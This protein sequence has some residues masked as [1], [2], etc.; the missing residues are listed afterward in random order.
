[1]EKRD[2]LDNMIDIETEDSLADS[3]TSN[4]FKNE[5]ILRIDGSSTEFQ[6]FFRHCLVANEPCIVSNVGADWPCYHLWVNQ[7]DDTP[8]LD[9]LAT[10]YTAKVSVAQCHKR[11]YNVQE[12]IEMGLSEYLA[13]WGRHREDDSEGCLYMK[14]WHFTRDFPHANVYRVPKF[15]A[16]DWLGEFYDNHPELGDDYRFVYM[17]P[18]HS[19]CVSL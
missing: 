7:H 16:S 2:I 19:W 13:Y 4:Q 6:F 17:G 3:H 15:F 8:N 14:D 12:K 10:H 18:K 9:Y 5:D 11:V 1:M